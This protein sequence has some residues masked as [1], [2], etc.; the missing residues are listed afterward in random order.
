MKIQPKTIIY[1]AFRIINRLFVLFI[2][3][4]NDDPVKEILLTTIKSL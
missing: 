1:S 2:Q 3:N 4:G